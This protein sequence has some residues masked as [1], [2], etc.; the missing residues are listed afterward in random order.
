LAWV[1]GVSESRDAFGMCEK[2]DALSWTPGVALRVVTAAEERRQT[3][4]LFEKAPDS[5]EQKR[6]CVTYCK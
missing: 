6:A 4:R 5:S 3:V 1:G 2:N